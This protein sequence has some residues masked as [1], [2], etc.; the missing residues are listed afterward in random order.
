MKMCRQLSSCLESQENSILH[1][2]YALAVASRASYRKQ[3]QPRRLARSFCCCPIC[4]LLPQA[5][6]PAVV[7]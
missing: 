7:R 5:F 1:L 6:I 4:S 3:P 2:I